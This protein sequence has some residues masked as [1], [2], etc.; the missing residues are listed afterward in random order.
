MNKDI[1]LLFERYISGEASPD[2]AIQLRSYFENDTDL[3]KWL[4]DQIANS[5]DTI[6][7]DIKI[8]M[9]E[10]IRSRTGYDTTLH[11]APIKKDNF[12]LY[13]RKI[14]NIAA[15]LLPVVII[16]GIWLYP[17][18]QKAGLFEVIADKGEKASLTLPEGS[19]VVINSDSK[20]TYYNDYNQKDRYVKLTG[21][22]YFEVKHNP[23]KTFIVEFGDVKVKVLGTSFGIKTYDN[24]ENVSIVLSSGKIRLIT[25]REEI[26]M[27][28]N[29]RIIYNKTTQTTTSEKV[30]ANDYTDWR[31]NRLRFENES[32]ETIMKTI[33]RMHN[34]DIVFEDSQLKNQ[35]FTGTINNTN[36]KDVLEAIRLTSSI[37]YRSKDSIVYLYENKVNH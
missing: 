6:D 28:P 19:K 22:A 15:V 18:T 16:L 3:N 33:S 13:L 4:E 7:P 12:K 29:D 35:R 30:D 9:L 34:T 27:T 8:R 21:E 14:S 5:P 24:E 37:D 20:I 23:E 11:V 36:I 10:N 17:E 25:P 2:E 31:Q 1:F 26:E 32:L